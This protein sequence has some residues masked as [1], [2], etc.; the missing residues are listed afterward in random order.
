MEAGRIS[1]GMTEK[2]RTLL[3][4]D[5]ADRARLL[6]SATAYAAGRRTYV[7]GAV[8]DVIAA[9]A[10]QLD[11]AA[12]E[13]LADAIRPA[14][15]EGDPIDAPAWTRALA[16]LETAAPD[17]LDGLDG[18]AVDLR[19][20]SC[21]P[22]VMSTKDALPDAGT[23]QCTITDGKDDSTVRDVRLVVTADNKVGLYD[24]DGK[25]LK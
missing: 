22:A 3:D 23:Y 8:S 7:V 25:A 11:A 9:N 16:A 24:A 6:A 12:R 10:G 18:N 5:P 17:D 1:T 13:A 19:N 21:S 20:L 15:D 14:M 2:K 4:I